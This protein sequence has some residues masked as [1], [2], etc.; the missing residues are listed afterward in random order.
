MKLKAIFYSALLTFSTAAVKAQTEIPAGYT[1]GSITLANATVITG[2]LKDNI[3]NHFF[4]APFHFYPGS[5]TLI[6]FV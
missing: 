1:K 4:A 6:K 2:Y 5:I 3:K